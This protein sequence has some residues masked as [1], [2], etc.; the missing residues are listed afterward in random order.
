MDTNF[1][2]NE[3]ELLLATALRRDAAMQRYTSFDPLVPSS[4]PTKLQTEILNDIN[5][6]IYRYVLGGN[7][8][9]KTSIGARECSWLFTN[10][11]PT[12]D[13]TKKWGDTPLVM[14]VLARTME[15]AQVNIWE[16]KIRPFLDPSEYK[17]IVQGQ[18]LQRVVN[19]KNGNLIIFHSH[20][21]PNE[22]REKVQSYSAHWVWLDEMPDSMPLIEE[23]HRRIQAMNG[24][25]LATF[26]PKL[27]N[28]DIRKL[29]ETPSS[30]HKKYK[31]PMFDNPIYHQRSAEIL[32][33]MS[34]L[35]ESLRNTILEG[36]WY[37]GTMSVYDFNIHQ[38]CRSLPETYSYS[39]RHIVSIDP[40]ASGKVGYSLLAEE[41]K[42]GTWYCV[43]AQY[44]DGAAASDLIPRIEKLYSNRNVVRRICD[45]H[46]T[47]FIKEAS[48]LKLYF[49]GVYKKNE[50]KMELIKNLQEALTN[51]KLYI[52]PE[53][54]LAVNELQSCQWSETNDIK[55]MK[56]SRFHILDSLQ[57]AIDNLPKHSPDFATPQSFISQLRQAN[58]ERIV[59][60]KAK[61]KRKKVWGR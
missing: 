45:P 19:P 31:L 2:A 41:P 43:D 16:R 27:R 47:W 32:A 6:T 20:H 54:Q 39:W 46:E 52:T 11:H 15:Q 60:E 26:T 58:R 61:L 7:Q 49:C 44:L 23:L 21:S 17:E 22:A 34:T 48:N 51:H 10:S 13:Q 8:S 30:V 29:I 4:R 38:H 53:C 9:G 37:I 40:A 36:D 18:V 56:A 33:S 3:I 50:R 59:K 42:T 35:S 24:R 5:S 1:H 28:D 14:M 25:F 12:F 55:I 57:Y